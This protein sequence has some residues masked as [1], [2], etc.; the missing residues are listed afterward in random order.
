MDTITTDRGPLQE[1][2]RRITGELDCA[3]CKMLEAYLLDQ[4]EWLT[5]DAREAFFDKI[6]RSEK[7]RTGA[8]L[9]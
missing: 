9:G 5:L 4:I 8:G 1:R 6:A 3:T 2:L 7:I